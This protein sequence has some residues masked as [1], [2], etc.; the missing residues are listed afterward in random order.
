Y[1]NIDPGTLNPYEHGECYV[2]VDGH[3]ADLDLGHY[4]RF[5]NIATTRANNVTTG[6]IY[7][8]VIDKERRGDYLGKTVQIIPH[9]TDEI[10]RN[11]KALG[12]TGNYDF[13]ITEI[14]GTVGDIESTPFLEAV[15]QLRWELGKN[16]LCIHL[17]Y[18]PYL[19]A[20]QELKTKP[21]QHSVKMLQS[22]GIQPDILV[23]RTEKEIP[24]SMLRKVAQFCN[25]AP[26]A[27]IQSL[28]APT[29]YQVPLMMH[30]QHLDDMVIE[31]TNSEV[32]TE[33]PDLDAWNLF[34]HK[35]ASAE[36]E[37]KI[38]LVGKYVELQ[39]AYKSISEALL[40]AAT[41]CDRKLNLTYI[42]SEKL[43]SQDVDEK[44]SN[45]DGVII[46]P[47]FGQRGIEGKFIALEWCRKHDIPTFGICLGM[48]CMV[49][50][51]ARN[52][53]GLQNANST[54]MDHNTPYNV[55][56]LMDEQK[57]ISNL[58]GTMRLGAYECRL[59]PGSIPAQAYKQEVI[60][61]RHRHRFEFNHEFRERFEEAGMQCVGENPQTG[62]VEVVQ[63]PALK[64]FVGTQYHP[65]YQSTVL[66]PNPLFISFVQAAVEYADN[67]TKA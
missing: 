3:E 67:K 63:I 8:S 29:I 57:S 62:L 1:I 33:K 9:I 4:E 36:K 40:Q 61:E 18:V 14:G 43:T 30:E 66:N 39:D 41:Y 60:S 6:R 55:I 12:K 51:F 2:T 13:V 56:D 21:T 24:S 35:L 48:Q 7:Q 44:L 26:H 20:A 10:K 16:S 27:V 38:G 23:L 37:V 46:A 5:T 11:V 28:N 42:H 54:E 53:L 22:V 58:G 45:L 19:K 65:E 25:V 47:G 15:R 64:W 31:M 34:L 32:R 59:K 52:V 17:T 50:E 49:I